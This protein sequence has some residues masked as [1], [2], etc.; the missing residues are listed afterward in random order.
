MDECEYTETYALGQQARFWNQS[1]ERPVPV[2]GILVLLWL[3]CMG[4][5]HH[6]P[7]TITAPWEVL[8]LQHHHVGGCTQIRI[9]H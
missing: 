9:T 2:A 8:G 7:A 5:S 1:E 4:V 3:H 6:A